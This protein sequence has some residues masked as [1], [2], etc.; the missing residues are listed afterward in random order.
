MAEKHWPSF[1]ATTIH[2]WNHI[3]IPGLYLSIINI[4][5][6]GYNV[7]STARLQGLVRPH[8]DN[9]SESGLLVSSG[10]DLI[11]CGCAAVN[12]TLRCRDRIA[13]VGEQLDFGSV[14]ATFKNCDPP[15][16]YARDKGVQE[17]MVKIV[18]TVCRWSIGN[19]IY[20]WRDQAV[21]D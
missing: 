13:A 8:K 16:K 18:L 6:F 11:L 20:K 7:L 5:T 2:D 21:D 12:K 1:R 3:I 15:S 4:A 10:G 14:I 17:Q 19:K 9:G